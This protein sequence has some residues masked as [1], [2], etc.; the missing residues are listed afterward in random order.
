[1]FCTSRI[2]ILGRKD[3]ES[4]ICSSSELL[5]NYVSHGVCVDSIPGKQ[6]APYKM[7]GKGNALLRIHTNDRVGKTRS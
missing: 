2:Q 3:V 7:H 6:N 1:M 5:P 4:L